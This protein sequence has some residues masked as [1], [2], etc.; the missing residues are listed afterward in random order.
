MNTWHTA[1]MN[2]E[3][4]S[5]DF[6]PHRVPLSG[7]AEPTSDFVETNFAASTVGET[8]DLTADDVDSFSS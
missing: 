3:G 5:F 7:V 4:R 8:L 2:G 1:D 6:Q